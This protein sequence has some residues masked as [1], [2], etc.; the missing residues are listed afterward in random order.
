[1]LDWRLIGFAAGVVAV[2]LGCMTALV[3]HGDVK[4]DVAVP[5]MTGLFSAFAGWLAPRPKV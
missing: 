4:A 1:M 5:A 2:G 3:M